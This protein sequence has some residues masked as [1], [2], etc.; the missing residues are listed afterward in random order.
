MNASN[1]NKNI[2]RFNL[3]EDINLV[4]KVD[5]KVIKALGNT[6]YQT[7]NAAGQG[8]KY[9]KEIG[10][11]KSLNPSEYNGIQWAVHHGD[12]NHTNDNRENLFILPNAAHSALHGKFFSFCEEVISKLGSNIDVIDY[13]ARVEQINVFIT[14]LNRKYPNFPELKRVE[15]PLSYIE[16]FASI[17]D[18]C[19]SLYSQTFMND[20][21]AAGKTWDI[22]RV[23]DIDNF[24]KDPSKV[25][26]KII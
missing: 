18:K 2:F 8:S 7:S 11:V 16:E 1:N 26:S 19:Y 14:A 12:G 23:V 6:I 20:I 10:A 22:Y 3:V 9:K 25:P 13:A 15:I 17:R 21:L 5:P 24:I 4:E